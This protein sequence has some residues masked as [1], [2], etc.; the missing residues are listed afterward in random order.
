MF[1]DL[2]SDEV[3]K[4]ICSLRKRTSWNIETFQLKD[5]LLKKLDAHKY[6][7]SVSTRS[8]FR[9]IGGT[10][11]SYLYMVPEKKRG[12]F[13]NYAGKLLRLVYVASAKDYLEIRFGEVENNQTGRSFHS[14]KPPEV[15]IEDFD[16]RRYYKF[17]FGEFNYNLNTTD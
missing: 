9:M 15:N 2:R 11:F 8:K 12:R 13:K 5:N 10:G 1:E 17:A 4:A 3:G 6:V 14:M 7:K 16:P